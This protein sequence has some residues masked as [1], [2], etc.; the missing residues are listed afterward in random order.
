MCENSQR[1]RKSTERFIDMLHSPLYILLYF[2]L[3]KTYD[4]LP[5]NSHFLPTNGSALTVALRE[6]INVSCNGESFDAVVCA[7]GMSDFYC[8]VFH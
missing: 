3:D 5:S 7:R 6:T 1:K 2:P 8:S 4:I